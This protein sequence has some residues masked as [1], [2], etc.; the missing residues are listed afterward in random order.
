MRRVN[1]MVV[2]FMNYGRPLK[3]RV[4]SLSYPELIAKVLPLL[5]DK[6]AE[7]RIEVVTKL[8]PDL[9]PMRADAELLRNC[10]INFITNAAQAMPEGGS[11]TLGASYDPETETFRLAFADQGEGIA[12]ED[13]PKIFQPYFTTKEA[14]IGLGLAITERIIREHGGEI[15]VESALGK[16]TTFTVVLPTKK[17][18]EV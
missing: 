14:G 15:L 4:S 12:A 16:G 5:Q 10:L 13:T 3:L 6:L 9:P 1:Y 11:I 7:Q 18:V 17:Q 8:A 2:N